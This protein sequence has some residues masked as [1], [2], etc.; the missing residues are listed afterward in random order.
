MTVAQVYAEI[1]KDHVFYRTSGGGVTVSGGEPLLWPNFVGALLGQV[2]RRLGVHTAIE[3]CGATPWSHFERVV[4]YLSHVFFDLKHMDCDTHRRLTGV[5]NER[6][7]DNL[8][9]LDAL[10]SVPI[11][12]RLPLIPGE[13]D[14]A[15]NLAATG[16]FVARLGNVAYVELLPFHRLGSSKY[17]SLGR[18]WQLSDR[19]PPARADLEQAAQ[20]IRAQGVTVE[21]GG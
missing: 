11:V 21:I 14:S 17:D 19:L 8:A 4:E 2:R 10:A 12:V 20:S 1:E 18:T 9:R 13:N 6:I 3:T 7:L 15:E 16:R 5:G